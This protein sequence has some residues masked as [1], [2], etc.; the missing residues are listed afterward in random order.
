MIE[1]YDLLENIVLIQLNL[2]IDQLD[3]FDHKEL[4]K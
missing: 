1:N 2:M 3:I 4:D